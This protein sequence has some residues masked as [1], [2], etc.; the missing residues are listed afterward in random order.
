MLESTARLLHF[1]VWSA[2]QT[3]TKGPP[4]GHVLPQTTDNSTKNH[5]MFFVPFRTVGWK[6]ILFC[7][8]AQGVPLTLL[9]HSGGLFC[10]EN[11]VKCGFMFMASHEL[12]GI[13]SVFW[14]PRQIWHYRLWHGLKTRGVTPFG[15]VLN[16]K[17]PE[18]NTI[19]FTSLQLFNSFESFEACAWKIKSG[20]RGR[21]SLGSSWGASSRRLLCETQSSKQ[22][23]PFYVARI[24][25]PSIEAF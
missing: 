11:A 4:R 12:L 8:L 3:R 17:L 21:I 14:D 2:H 25:L 18:S 7:W 6:E 1:V 23:A 20:R 10:H 24:C 16:F 15:Q 22:W 5:R 13:F 9:A 19:H